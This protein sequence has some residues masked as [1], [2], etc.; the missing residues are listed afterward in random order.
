MMGIEETL[1]KYKAWVADHPQL[2]GDAEACLRWLSYLVA[3]TARRS[4]LL[5]ELLYSAAGLVTF[6]HDRIIAGAHPHLQKRQ[7]SAIEQLLSVIDMV[8]VF[9][10]LA[11]SK[12]AGPLGKWAAVSSIVLLKTCLR[13]SLALSGALL[14]H[15]P[16]PPLDRVGSVNKP[17]T[18]HDAVVTITLKRS[19]RTMRK[20]EG[21]P[22][23]LARDWTLPKPKL[24]PPGCSTPLSTSQQFAEA[25]HVLQPL[26]H[27]LMLAACGPQA[28]SPLIISLAMDLSSQALHTGMLQPCSSLQEP[29]TAE[30]ARRRLHLLHYLLRSP[31]YDQRSKSLIVSLLKFSQQNVPLAGAISKAL[32]RYLPEYQKIYFYVW[33]Y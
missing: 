8:E 13:L 19:G 2:V 24:S 5:S 6:L 3:G 26:T 25:L 21:S 15:P 23:I 32:L 22:P 9:L 12:V 18:I 14:L 11:A 1:A 30:L 7:Y 20:V 31:L 4:V 28:W 17:P 16:I 27:L 10:E 29:E 33:S